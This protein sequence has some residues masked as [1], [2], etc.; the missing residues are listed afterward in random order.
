MPKR[1]YIVLVLVNTC[2][3]TAVAFLVV[4]HILPPVILAI[5]GGAVLL[6]TAICVLMLISQRTG[7][8]SRH[9][10]PRLILIYVGIGV[11]GL[12]RGLSRGWTVGDTIGL[13]TLT[14]VGT[15]YTIL[16]Y[17]QKREKS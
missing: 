13:I 14:A 3:I 17:R 4:K 7:G 15:G 11:L 16:Y 8:G 10:V 5:A 9:A 6:G 12:A 2:V 1:A